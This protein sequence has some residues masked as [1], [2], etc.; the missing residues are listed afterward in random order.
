MGKKKDLISR[1]Q[2]REK[3][4]VVE[5]ERSS[6]LHRGKSTV[7]QYTDRGFKKYSKREE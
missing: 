1:I 3:K 7:R 6:I 4:R 2:S 5:L